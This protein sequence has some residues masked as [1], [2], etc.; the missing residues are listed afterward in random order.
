VTGS[1]LVLSL[2]VAAYLIG[3][4]LLGANLF[5][6]HPRLVV[7]GRLTSIGGALLHMGAIGLRC[8]ELKRAPF[9]TPAESL[10]LLAWIVALV[11][12]GMDL[13]G[14]LTAAGPF[15]LSLSFLLVLL[16]ATL[17]TPRALHDDHAALLASNAISL[18]II[19][20]VGAIAVFA[21]A[22]CCSALY[23]TAHRI[24]KS[25]HGLVWMKRLPPLT[26]VENAAFILTAIGFP[27][28]T[29]GILA[30]FVRAANG[31]LPQHWASDPK[32]LLSYAVWGVYALYLLAR[33]TLNWPPV[34]TSY[35][36]IV[37][38]LLSVLLFLVPT[39]AHRFP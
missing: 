31:G 6:R 14:R 3:A 5:L 38:L 34:R 12:I 37:G 22:F 17:P 39:T 28:L 33:L 27:L 25:K 4:V 36:L 29:L 7:S 11:F 23:L 19:A 26:T 18:H 13:R 30:G 10:S 21:L 15:A 1:V 35:I 32:T 2:T 16:A 24:L 20:T 8:A 9:V